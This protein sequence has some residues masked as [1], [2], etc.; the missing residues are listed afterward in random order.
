VLYRFLV[1]GGPYVLPVL[2]ASIVALALIL[3]RVWFFASLALARDGRLRRRMLSGEPPPPAGAPITDPVARVLAEA[4][5][6][7]DDMTLAWVRG[8]DALREARANV[9]LLELTGAAAAVIG[10]LGTALAS[11]EVFRATA[12]VAKLGPGLA[13][14]LHPLIA[15]LLVFLAAIAFVIVFRLLAASL[16]ARVEEAIEVSKKVRL[17]TAKHAEISARLAAA[18][19]SS[20]KSA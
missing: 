1:D 6:N 11:R 19:H 15:G 14:A 3:E 10:V 5:R 4:L 13:L 2:A 20:E 8:Q 12:D 7:P 16:E 9:F 18:S 17:Q